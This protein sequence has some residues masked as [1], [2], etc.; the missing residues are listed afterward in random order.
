VKITLKSWYKNIL[1]VALSTLLT[2]FIAEIA[3]R[4]ISPHDQFSSLLPNLDAVQYNRYYNYFPGIDSVFHITVNESGYRSPSTFGLDRYGILTIGGSTTHCVGLSDV[5]S[6]PW[7]LENKLNQNSHQKYTVGN[8]AALGHHSGN[9]LLQLKHM[10]PQFENI[11]MVLI[12]VGINDFRRFFISD[13]HYTPTSQ[14]KHL[15]NRTFLQYPI[16]FAEEWYQKTELWLNIRDARN[17]YKNIKNS[18]KNHDLDE[19]TK[20]Y[21]TARQGVDLMVKKYDSSK[22]TDELVDITEAVKDFETNLKEIVSI[23]HNRNIKPVFIT[24]PTLWNENMSKYEEKIAAY[25]S[26]QVNGAFLSPNAME[27]GLEL[28]NNKLRE[29]SKQDNVELIELALHL[30]K[31]TSVFFDDCH[32]NKSGSAKVASFVYTELTELLNKDARN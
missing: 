9:H 13:T 27:I 24:Q 31:D 17:T 32:F 1:V 22:K 7:L 2:L 12:L 26:P 29:I 4:V 15:F 8:I 28:F 5:D 30:P 11:K 6:W 14:D 25:S 19:L 20:R 23:A 16:E 3:L 10:E 21:N 18:N